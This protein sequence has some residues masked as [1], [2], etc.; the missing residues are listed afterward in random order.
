MKVNK[1]TL[2]RMKKLSY[3]LKQKEKGEKQEENER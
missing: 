3:K 2:I 1:I